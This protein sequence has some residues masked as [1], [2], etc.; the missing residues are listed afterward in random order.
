MPRT[1]VH[2]HERKR[3]RKRNRE[4]G[5]KERNDRR[6]MEGARPVVGWQRQLPLNA[7]LDR[8]EPIMLIIPPIILSG[9]AFKLY[10]LFPKLCS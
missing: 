10:L 3:E 2:L 8:H 4:G 7:P 6:V 5:R 9:N 1:H